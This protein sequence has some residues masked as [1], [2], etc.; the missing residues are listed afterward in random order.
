MK[1]R[2]T[3]APP[4]VVV[5][6]DSWMGNPGGDRTRRRD[7]PDEK[8]QAV[9]PST[10]ASFDMTEAYDSVVEFGSTSFVGREKREFEEEKQRELGRRSCPC[11][12]A[13]VLPFFDQ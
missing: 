3:R 2:K 11:C 12:C 9:G 13:A 7:E 6:G 5:C 10:T 4:V 8:T 1:R